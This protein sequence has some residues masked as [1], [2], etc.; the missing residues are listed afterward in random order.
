VGDVVT[1]QDPNRPSRLL[2]HR[3]RHIDAAGST[4]RFSTK[5]DRNDT[6]EQ[7]SVSRQGRISRV[8]LRL[9]GMGFVMFWLNGP[10]SRFGLIVVPAVLLG[11]LELRKLWRARPAE[12]VHAHP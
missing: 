5:G 10:L 6:V 7:W 1:F 2:T 11:L 9:R 4:V 8:V 12:V 3:V